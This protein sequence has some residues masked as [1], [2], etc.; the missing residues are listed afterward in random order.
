M[1]KPVMVVF[2]YWG[3]MLL[4]VMG[5]GFE[6]TYTISGKGNVSRVIPGLFGW[7]YQTLRLSPLVVEH[8]VVVMTVDSQSRKKTVPD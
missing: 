7:F 5:V 6:N 4:W 1:N 3:L 8:T 2:F